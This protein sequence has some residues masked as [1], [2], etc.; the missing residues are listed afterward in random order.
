MAQELGNMMNDDIAYTE[1]LKIAYEALGD[2]VKGPESPVVACMFKECAKC[3]DKRSNEARCYTAHALHVPPTIMIKDLG[4]KMTEKPE[5]AVGQMLNAERR[6][7][8]STTKLYKEL[9]DRRE[10][11]GVKEYFHLGE[12]V[13]RH[14][15]VDK[16]RRIAWLTNVYSSKF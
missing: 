12:H 4:I 2:I 5:E 7:F 1:S 6:T 9:C 3:I 16:E 13:F 8:D 14:I 15:L 10:E 11:D